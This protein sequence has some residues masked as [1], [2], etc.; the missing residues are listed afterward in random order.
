M[1]SQE[2]HALLAP[3][4]MGFIED[5]MIDA[6]VRPEDLVNRADFVEAVDTSVYREDVV[7]ASRFDE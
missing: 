1:T 2:W 4:A 6:I 5:I 7:L 3:E